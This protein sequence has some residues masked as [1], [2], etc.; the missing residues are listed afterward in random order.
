MEQK[1]IAD[2]HIHSRFA[3]ATSKNIDI[4][5]LAKY[6]KIKGLSLFGT[7]DFQHPEWNKELSKLEERDGLLYYQDF[8]FLWQTEISLMYSQGEKGR[9][10]HHVILVPDGEVA[11]QVTDFLA[12]KG[13]LDYDGRPIFGFSSIELVDEIERISKDI[14]IIP[15]HC[16]PPEE[17]IICKNG[18]VPISD[19]KKG[20]MVLTH[21]GRFK[22]VYRPGGCF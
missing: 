2:L 12:S 18:L 9:R 5:N 3:R 1:I 14:E 6:A 11:R 13:R 17:D 7:G 8:P 20:Q 22:K 19:V 15:A 21:N 10:I 4:P 16:L